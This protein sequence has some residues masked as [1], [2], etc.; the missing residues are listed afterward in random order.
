RVVFFFF[1]SRRRHTSSKRDWSSDVCSSDLAFTAVE[2]PGLV[3][4]VDYELGDTVT[5]E[6]GPVTVTEPVRA[7]EIAWDGYGRTVALTLGDHD[8]ADDKTPAWV[9]YIKKLDL[10]ARVRSM[11]VR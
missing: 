5:V 9:K 11:E 4:G 3:Y 1:S 10:E 2:T 6:L 8:Q 7:V